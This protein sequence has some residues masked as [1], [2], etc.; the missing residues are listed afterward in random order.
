MFYRASTKLPQTKK[1]L[2]V[3]ELVLA[4]ESLG[5]VVGVDVDLGKSVVDTWI[6]ASLLNLDFEPGEEKLEKN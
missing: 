6:S 2:R 4:K 1:N 5:V 3:V